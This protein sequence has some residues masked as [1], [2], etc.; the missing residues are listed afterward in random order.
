MG[1]KRAGGKE[2]PTARKRAKL[3]E[4]PIIPERPGALKISMGSKRAAVVEMPTLWQRAV[5]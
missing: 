3:L 5:G 2:M 1:S 4:M